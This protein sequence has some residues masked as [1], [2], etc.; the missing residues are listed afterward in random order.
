MIIIM[1]YIVQQKNFKIP[2]GNTID[3]GLVVWE[4]GRVEVDPD[5]PK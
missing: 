1:K 5:I 2:K 4:V 3:F